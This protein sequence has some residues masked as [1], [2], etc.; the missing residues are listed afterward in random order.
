MNQSDY[1]PD[2]TEWLIDD[3]PDTYKPKKVISTSAGDPLAEIDYEDPEFYVM[4]KLF[5]DLKNAEDK[6]IE[7]MKSNIKLSDKI[8]DIINIQNDIK[9]INRKL[10]KMTFY[11]KTDKSNIKNKMFNKAE[12]YVYKY[13]ST[14]DN[15]ILEYIENHFSDC[16]IGFV[17]WYPTIPKY[18]LY[19]TSEVD[20]KGKPKK[21]FRL[22]KKIIK[23]E[24]LKEMN[25]K[26]IVI[27]NIYIK[28]IN[29][30]KECSEYSLLEPQSNKFY[31]QQGNTYINKICALLNTRQPN[32]SINANNIKI[33][34]DILFKELQNYFECFMLPMENIINIYN[35]KYIINP[36]KDE[37]IDPNNY[38]PNNHVE[39]DIIEPHQS[40]YNTLKS[41]KPVDNNLIFRRCKICK[42]S[43]IKDMKTHFK[44]FDHMGLCKLNDYK[45][46]SICN[47]YISSKYHNIIFQKEHDDIREFD[48]WFATVNIPKFKPDFNK[49]VIDIPPIKQLKNSSDLALFKA[50]HKY[51]LK[52]AKANGIIYTD[53]EITKYGG[54]PDGLKP[55][56]QYSNY[57][58]PVLFPSLHEWQCMTMDEK[59]QEYELFGENYELENEISYQ[60]YQRLI[61]DPE[62]RY[63]Q[64]TNN[65]PKI[66]N[67]KLPSE[68]YNHK[69]KE[70]INK[71]SNVIRQPN[72]NI[73]KINIP[74]E[75]IKNIKYWNDDVCRWWIQPYYPGFQFKVLDYKNDLIFKDGKI[76]IECPLHHNSIKDFNY[77]KKL[78]IKNNIKKLCDV[79]NGG[80][81]FIESPHINCN[82][83]YSSKKYKP[84]SKYEKLFYSWAS[85]YMENILF[86][87]IV[88]PYPK[89]N[90]TK[91]FKFDYYYKAL[92]VFFEIDGQQ[93][94][95]GSRHPQWLSYEEQHEI[96][97]EKDLYVKSKNY[98]L[99]RIHHK[100]IG[101]LHQHVIDDIFNNNIKGIIYS[102]P[103]YYS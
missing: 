62:I 81:H 12:Y 7:I 46:C 57:N 51:N 40:V 75:I 74:I 87:Y 98:K 95:P 43:N 94:F 42:I 52:K 77:I 26:F 33:T 93:H 90:P 86:E 76:Y 25:D 79:C 50:K 17:S 9:S 5:E 85:K 14:N 6:Y 3:N 103:N 49:I 48:D 1:F 58:C 64:L 96:D 37:I 60:E 97:L 84:S 83:T 54:L 89:E 22:S 41:N 63:K 67:I 53:D 56:P 44:T 100:D 11:V 92:N 15:K 34:F 39:S 71:N 32:I 19:D 38:N 78:L 16:N 65:I 73:F 80:K 88:I 61:S 35:I 18:T 72:P 10:D 28:I 69:M 21:A 47:Y 91:Y 27:Y 29:L 23:S 82:I 55:K 68:L 70:H 13:T 8:K 24:T 59:H 99:V 2:D 66:S 4:R 30:I 31:I 36:G 101:A 20:K 45:I 102:R